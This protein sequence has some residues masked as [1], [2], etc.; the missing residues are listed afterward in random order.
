MSSSRVGL[1]TIKEWLE[2]GKDNPDTLVDLKWA[3]IEE[4]KEQER[5]VSLRA[6][7]PSL[8]INLL[9]LLLTPQRLAKAGVIQTI[10]LVIETDIPTVDLDPQE[11]LFVYRDLLSS[12]RLPLVKFYIYGEHH[13]IGI[14]VDLDLKSLSKAEFN[15]AL[16]MLMAAYLYLRKNEAFT[17]YLRR[18]ELMMLAKLVVNYIRKGASKEE[19]IEYL[20]ESGVERG[21]AEEIV[22]SIYKLS[23]ESEQDKGKTSESMY[24]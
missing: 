22:D 1:E 13:F 7:H 4:K 2:E 17:R 6:S 9:I 21:Q 18:E 24:I 16:A 11:K 15:D 8:P 19:I 23:G 10:R 3:I 5:L 20:V 14:A 12:S